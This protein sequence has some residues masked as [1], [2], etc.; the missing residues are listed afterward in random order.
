MKEGLT[1]ER[2]GGAVERCLQETGAYPAS[3][4]DL[5]PGYLPF[6]LG[7]L[8]ISGNPILL[9]KRSCDNM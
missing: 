7:P 4:A 8:R 5:T 1:I 3:L 9:K 2:I 6:I